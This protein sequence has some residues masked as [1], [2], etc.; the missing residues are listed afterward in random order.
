MHS[1]FGFT[2]DKDALRSVPSLIAKFNPSGGWYELSGLH[3]STGRVF[4]VLT[5]EMKLCICCIN[6]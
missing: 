6:Y 4:L 2:K 1:V 3:N 5:L